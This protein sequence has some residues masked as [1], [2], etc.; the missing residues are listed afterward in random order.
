MHDLLKTHFGYDE[1]RPLQEDIINTILAKQDALVLMPTGGGKS[2][3][4]QLPAL[5]FSGLTLVISPLI[6]LMKDQ[7]DGLQG[8]GIAAAFINSTLSFAEIRDVENQARS[9][10]IK[11]LYLAPERL[12]LPGF[13][14]FLKT[15]NISLI[16]VDEAHC[17]SEW[18]HDFR[19]DYRNLKTLRTDF[20][21]VPVIAL[22][23]TATERV[24]VDIKNE[25]SLKE[26]R[27]FISS[28]NRPN[29][30]YY[31][32]PK[33]DTFARL[34][35]LLKKHA[36]ESTIIYC[37][38]RRDT[39]NVAADLRAEGFKANPYHAGLEADVRRETQEQFIRDEAPI[40]VATI[41]F[42]MGIDKPDIRLVVHYDLP[43]TIEGY[44]QETG[45][46]GRDGLPSDCVLFYSYGD[47]RKHYFFIEQMEDA[48][49]RQHAETKLGQVVAFCENN[50]CRRKFL[51]AYFGEDWKE[52]SCERCDTCLTPRENFNATEI[53]Q[54]IL[55]AVLRTGERYG[56]N[57]VIE[58]LRGS[59]AEEIYARGH[60]K[61]S[62]FGIVP[63]FKKT[64]LRHIMRQLVS[65]GLLTKEAGIYPTLQVSSAGR[66]WLRDRRQLILTKAH[67]ARE[68]ITEKMEKELEY[69]YGLFEELRGLRK[70]LADRQGV[71]PFVVFGDRA[72]RE[73][74][75]YVPQSL[76]N[77]ARISGVGREKLTRYG[78]IFTRAIRVYAEAHNLTERSIRSTLSFGSRPSRSIKREGSTYAA[79]KQLLAD[80]LPLTEIARR[81]GLSEDTV[82]NHIEKLVMAGDGLDLEPLR[83]PADRFAAIAKAF[84]QTGGLGLTSVRELLG[85][86]FSYRELKIARLFL[87]NQNTSADS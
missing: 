61:L 25:L 29:L 26:A 69:D 67:A 80:H 66:E 37:F 41:A 84:E 33:N 71:P 60:E 53:T 73:M 22:T 55:S 68:F 50:D 72:L 32:E 44:Y 12:A 11:I 23:A 20:S 82:L 85:E 13:R 70:Q 74:A 10:K 36:N 40:I 76:E 56:A 39:E 15:L 47:T 1:F 9:G 3:C 83:P 54:K 30:I 14:Q 63:D 31:I 52:E 57:Y 43:K 19:P 5:H 8:N 27:L 58:V 28:F 16:A 81:R 75:S 77:F 64:D 7:V 6:A 18:G 2:L 87:Q 46:A 35:E 48:V 42:G 17:I 59:R 78:D 21:E 62:V 86:D 38:S 34:L 79:T 65:Q 24:R 4:Y 49:E 51:L 45:R